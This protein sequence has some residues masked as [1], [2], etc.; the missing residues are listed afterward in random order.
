M[1]TGKEIKNNEIKNYSIV[2]GT[3]N[4]KNPKSIYLNLSAWADP[5][6]E[7][8]LNYNFDIRNLNKNIKQTLFNYLN[9]NNSI[10]NK[11]RTIVDLDIRESGI[12]FGKRSFMNCEITFFMKEAVSINS[13]E[14]TNDL[15]ILTKILISLFDSNKTFNF[16]KKKN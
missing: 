13:I 16:Y 1:K 4:N 15:E 12:K 2:Y 10:F 14:I 6:N 8:Y 5:L 7:E 11:D 9:E 3:V